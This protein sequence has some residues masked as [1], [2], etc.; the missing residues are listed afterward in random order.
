MVAWARRGGLHRSLGWLLTRI[1]FATST[2]LIA[3]LVQVIPTVRGPGVRCRGARTSGSSRARRKGDRQGTG[4]SAAGPRPVLIMFG[5]EGAWHGMCPLPTQLPMAPFPIE[6]CGMCPLPTRR[7]GLDVSVAYA[8]CRRC[9]RC[10]RPVG[11]IL[12]GIAMCLLPTGRVSLPRVFLARTRTC[13]SYPC[14]PCRRNN[15]KFVQSLSLD[16]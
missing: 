13:Y 1:A 14:V 3:T 10:L 12:G 2:C 7:V 15:K 16:A 6:S 4:D 5:L 11:G 9:V 8:I